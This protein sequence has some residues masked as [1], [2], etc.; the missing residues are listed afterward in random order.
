[1]SIN[2]GLKV[3]AGAVAL[4][5]AGGAM[6]NTSTNAG[7]SGTIFLNIEDTTNGTSF[8]YDTG[9][10]AA[11]FTGTSS[12]SAIS[13]AGDANYQAF[14]AGKGA[15]DVV[16]YSVLGS[17]TATSPLVNTLF[18]ST[19]PPVAQSGN[20]I[21]G[22]AT[23][24]GTFLGAI[25]TLTSAT[26]NSVYQPVGANVSTNWFVSGNEGTL[27]GDLNINS[28]NAAIGTALAFYTTGTSNINSTT[29]IGSLSTF[30]GSW[31][32]DSSGSLSYNVG[33]TPVPLPTP[34]LLLLSGLGLMG[35]VA[36]RGQS[37]SS[38]ARFD[39]ATA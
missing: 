25:N 34:L 8:M 31:T 35:L 30:A 19:S 21:N 12:I 9:L 36:R 26:T 2:T 14:L 23:Q 32:L 7:P 27:T 37:S 1:M 5:F 17:Y 16:D 29:K 15:S 39:G 4:A 24:I 33:T 18:T 28:D 10:S 13:L 22:S 6:A 20:L 3:I 38:E 11:S